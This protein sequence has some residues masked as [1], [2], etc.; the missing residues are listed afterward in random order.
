MYFSKWEFR[1]WI[2]RNGNLPCDFDGNEL[3]CPSDNN[4]IKVTYGN[5]INYQTGFRKD[6]N[7]IDNYRN[8]ICLI[9]KGTNSIGQKV[10]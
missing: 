7:E 9:N 3:S 10:L 5:N 8:N 6:N 4:Y 2:L 1:I